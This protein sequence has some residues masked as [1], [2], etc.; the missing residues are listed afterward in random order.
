MSSA[1]LPEVVAFV[2]ARLNKVNKTFTGASINSPGTPGTVPAPTAG[3]NVRVLT[4]DGSWTTVNITHLNLKSFTQW[5]TAT[6]YDVQGLFLTDQGRLFRVQQVHTSSQID[7]DLLAGKLSEIGGMD[8][9]ATT[10]TA[11][12]IYD[13]H[14]IAVFNGQLV[15]SQATHV[16]TTFA[17]DCLLGIWKFIANTSFSTTPNGTSY[18]SFM[19]HTVVKDNRLW[20]CI[21]PHVASAWIQANWLSLQRDFTGATL[22]LD[23]AAGMVPAPGAGLTTR[24]LTADGNWTDLLSL[25]SQSGQSAQTTAALAVLNSTVTT[26]NSA[27][28]TL[29]TNVSTLTANLT[30]LSKSEAGAANP[31]SISISTV[32]TTSVLGLFTPVDTSAGALTLTLPPSPSVGDTYSFIDAKSTWATN[33]VTISAT[34]IQGVVQTAILDISGANVTFKYMNTVTGWALLSD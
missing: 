11:G 24:A 12:A 1:T 29:Q 32:V 28:S 4:S 19:G 15:Q 2:N 21:T 18:Y 34:M 9:V 23:G 6:L 8:E 3:P 10:W 31:N 22:N 33:N 7:A 30:N 5:Q 13:Q 14:H 17:A 25:V 26:L 20:S 27:V 16:A